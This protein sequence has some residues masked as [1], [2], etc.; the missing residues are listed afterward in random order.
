MTEKIYEEN[1]DID[2][3]VIGGDMV[4]SPT[5]S[6]Q[7]DMFLEHCGVFSRLPLM[8]VSGNHEGVSSNNTYKKIFAIPSNGPKKMCIRDRVKRG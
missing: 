7:W 2:F 5:D 1:N 4:N 6:Y 3:A 8:T